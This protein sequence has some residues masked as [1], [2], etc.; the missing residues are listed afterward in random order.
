MQF[1]ALILLLFT[2]N[3]NTSL[4]QQRVA[5]IATYE[6]K[7]DNP[8]FSTDQTACSDGVNGLSKNFPNLGSI[9]G[10]PFIAASP[11]ISGWNSAEC[12]KC[13]ILH[14]K[15]RTVVVKGVDMANRFVLSKQAL[16]KLTN[17]MASALGTVSVDFSPTACP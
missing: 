3:I 6:E 5:V 14:Y 1:P 16:D 9:P 7:Y 11:T 10:H 12:G 15:G 4:A 13:Y 17:G 2:L 8:N